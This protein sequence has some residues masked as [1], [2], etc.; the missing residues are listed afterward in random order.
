M[1]PANRL[2]ILPLAAVIVACASPI[3]PAPSAT[4]V[5]TEIREASPAASTAM[6]SLAPTLPPT[7]TGV[8]TPLAPTATRTIAPKTP[9]P[10]SPKSGLDV[11]TLLVGPGQPARLYALLASPFDPTRGPQM[12]LVVSD[13]QGATWS[14]FSGG[15]PTEPGCM[16]NVNLDYANPDAL[17][18][19]TCRG[20]YRWESNHWAFLSQLETGMV[21]V[22]YGKPS[23][24]W[25]I[26]NQNRNGPIVRSLDGGATWNSAS[27]DLAHFTGIADLAIDP[28]DA[29]TLYAIINPKYAGSYL[30]RGNAQGQWQTMPTPLNDSVIETGMTID[31]ASGS[32]FVTL[33]VFSKSSN[34]EWQLWRT[35]SP[36][37]PDLHS[38]AWEM[39]HG[40]GEGTRVT[41]LASGAG[42]Q[43]LDI[44][45]ECFPLAGGS[46]V[47]RST[48]GGHTWAR[49]N[50][51][52]S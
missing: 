32:L 22:V 3:L 1:I 45:V 51:P 5:P 25:A 34:G 21:A 41:V 24:I 42:S 11:L 39:V 27:V 44:Y 18:A 29:N 52:G 49:V 48:D 13:D 37:A 47:Q 38:V 16:H 43:G 19:S 26:A 20:I 10:S 12:R 46:Y 30:R 50:L 14:T 6:P 7:L 4:F 36:G 23:A 9:T 40:F 15:L 31:G 33:P 28:R 17:Y 35:R 8:P 2:P